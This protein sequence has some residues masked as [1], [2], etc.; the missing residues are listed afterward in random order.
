MA[1]FTNTATLSFNGISVTSNTVSGEL[2]EVLS[3][4]KTAVTE[5]YAANRDV[6]FVISLV[7]SGQSDLTGLTVSDDLGAYTYNTSVLTPLTYVDGSVRYYADG[8]LQAA[9][10]VTAGPPLNISGIS[11]PA[12]GNAMLIYEAMVNEYAPLAAEST[13]TNTA[14]VSSAALTAAITASET[15][16]AAESPLLTVTKLMDP[17]AVATGD[18]LTYTFIINNNGSAAAAAP[19][20]A[21][22]IVLN[23][24]F[25][26]A[27]TITA[28]TFNGTAWT[29]G[30]NYTYDAGTGSFA[31]MAGQITVPAA[32]YSQNEDGAWVTVPGI[33]TLT[34][35][36][37]V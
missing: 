25:D 33:S 24:V 30:A 21:D 19:A 34:V 27:L 6:T 8:V 29:E 16:T 22:D 37:T 15:I 9:P 1:T 5:N 3:A 7:N 28:V 4:A 10:V 23:D 36:G 11:V 32:T 2:L 13:I 26:P 35:A 12:G 20:A 14:S 18:T 17:V 31:T